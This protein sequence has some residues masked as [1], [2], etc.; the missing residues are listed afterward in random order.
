MI[1]ISNKFCP[2]GVVLLLT[3]L[4]FFFGSVAFGQDCEKNSDDD[5]CEE[6]A[7]PFAS[8][9]LK[10]MSKK[11]NNTDFLHEK[12]TRECNSD[13]K[14]TETSCKH[15]FFNYD[16]IRIAPGNWE[17]S[18]LLSWVYQIL[19]S[20]LLDV[21]VTIDSNGMGLSS[22][23][24]KSSGFVYS[25][26]AY[27]LDSL[28]IA[29]DYN[30][31]CIS[32]LADGK[33]SCAHII[34]EVWVG[35]SETIKQGQ[36][37]GYLLPTETNGMIGQ[38]GLFIPTHTAMKDWSLTSHHGLSNNRT[39]MAEHFG[40][41]TS[42]REY[43]SNISNGNCTNDDGVAARMPVNEDEGSSYYIKGL[44]NGHFEKDDCV[45]HPQTC[46]GYFVNAPCTWSTYAE[47]QMFW[48]NISLISDGT[49][50]ENKGYT[51]TQMIQIL[52][53]SNQTKEDLLMWWFLPDMTAQLF[54]DTPSSLYHVKLPKATQACLEA[55][56]QD[57][58]S[59][60]KDK[61]LGSR[62]GSCDYALNPLKKVISKGLETMTLAND[63]IN[64]SPSLAFLNQINV[65]ATALD[66]ILQD[67]VTASANPFNARLAVCEWVYSN[68]EYLERQ[69]PP[70]YPR[71]VN[72]DEYSISLLSVAVSF[73]V[74]AL[75]ITLSS[76]A[77]TIYRRDHRILT[78]SR[79]DFLL[80]ILVGFFFVTIASVLK[81]TNPSPIS[82]S[83]SQW[84]V[85]LGFTLQFVP[86]LIKI[87]AINRITHQSL[88]MNRV[89]FKMKNLKKVVFSMIF[90]I[91]VYLSIWTFFDANTKVLRQVFSDREN[92][93]VD[94]SVKC[95]S[96]SS[97]WN[98]VSFVWEGVLLLCILVLALQS[99]S[100]IAELNESQ[101]L[102]LMVY[103]HFLFLVLRLIVGWMGLLDLIMGNI[104]RGI[105]S[106]LLSLDSILCIVIYFGEKFHKIFVGDRRRSSTTTANSSFKVRTARGSVIT[107]LKNPGR[108]TQSLIVTERDKQN[109][110]GLARDVNKISVNGILEIQK[111][112]LLGND[113]PRTKKAPPQ[114]PF[115]PIPANKSDDDLKEGVE[116]EMFLSPN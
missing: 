36:D 53:A 5:D 91:I 89:N 40:R 22:F 31:D 63:E 4:S 18:I 101:S 32:A 69:L 13:D 76:A 38:L 108:F 9:C 79:V 21:P 94:T 33:T 65:P 109:R 64:R 11:Y 46:T 66:E 24:D 93:I 112:E 96:S 61:R 47:A 49:V 111:V 3:S 98:I 82:C 62:I 104:E 88:S 42:W 57:K 110:L 113:C 81:A 20:E 54:S 23:Y 87:A 102:T 103:T 59:S 70:S 86:L 58:C 67:W 45:A 116:Q 34:P 39:K 107:G 1:F 75:V 15:G 52:H 19:M 60:D 12:Y 48:N 84:A 16:E 27:N 95:A 17:S 2:L 51:Y 100:L 85:T 8:G 74:I 72:Q 44:F 35:P 97:I 26:V 25:D 14:S 6:T 56:P 105:I 106:L 99:E 80:F 71:T 92:G 78:Y 77:I 50:G 30:G 83:I 43:C 10:A 37:E 41:P 7:N 28:K 115:F 68:I 90:L 55:R 73:G 29:H 114:E